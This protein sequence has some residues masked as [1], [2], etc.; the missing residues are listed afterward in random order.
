MRALIS[1]Q[2]AVDK[3]AAETEML[4]RLMQDPE[5]NRLKL[6]QITEANAG[7]LS[8]V[9]VASTLTPRGAR[10]QTDGGRTEVGAA[11]AAAAGGLSRRAGQVRGAPQGIGYTRGRHRRA[12]V[13]GQRAG[14]GGAG[15]GGSAVLAFLGG[16]CSERGGTQD[17]LY[18][19]L[20][21]Q[22]K[23]MEKGKLR[24]MHT[25]KIL[26]GLNNVKKQNADIDKVLLDTRDLK[27]EINQ[28]TDAL[29]RSF[30][31]VD[32]LI[33]RDAKCEAFLFVFGLASPPLPLP[34]R[35]GKRAFVRASQFAAACRRARTRQPR[36]RT[37]CWWR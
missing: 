9:A 4:R 8:C 32:E 18:R 19:Q 27:K 7:A 21:E 34:R 35:V 3:E 29:S 5:G 11:S 28:I 17:Q 23:T 16:H 13:Q 6:I 15:E 36:P 2:Q 31:V 25:D 37:S 20:L 10:R 12:S 1:A 24:S 22:W 14:G 30:A 33:Y 26:E